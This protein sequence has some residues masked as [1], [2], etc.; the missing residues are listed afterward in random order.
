LVPSIEI[1]FKRAVIFRSV[2]PHSIVESCRRAR[3]T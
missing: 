2:T 1:A 3:R